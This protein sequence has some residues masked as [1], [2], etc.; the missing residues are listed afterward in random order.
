MIFLRPA[1]GEYLVCKAKPLKVGKR[2]CVVSVEQ[3]NDRGALVTTA[4]FTFAVV[5]EVEPLILPPRHPG[6]RDL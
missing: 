2:I 1:A 3:Y 6:L 5:E 4:L